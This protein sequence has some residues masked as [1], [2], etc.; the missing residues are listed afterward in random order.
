[1]AF[2]PITNKKINLSFSLLPAPSSSCCWLP[3]CILKYHFHLRSLC[4][5]SSSSL[6]FRIHVY[7]SHFDGIFEGSF[8]LSLFPCHHP[9]SPMLSILL[10]F[11]V[12][13]FIC[14]YSVSS[15]HLL[16]YHSNN[17]CFNAISIYFLYKFLHYI[18]FVGIDIFAISTLYLS[19]YS[20]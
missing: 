20:L 17:V 6:W 19:P 3:F 7:I 16:Y 2:I 8:S 4:V 11:C 12:I 10:R 18:I 14:S 1:M 5:F 9:F 15:F 13:L